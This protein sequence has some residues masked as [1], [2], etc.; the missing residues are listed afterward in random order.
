[1]DVVAQAGRKKYG[2]LL[3][4]QSQAC[5]PIA[6]SN[7]LFSSQLKNRIVMMTKNRSTKTASIKYL[8][9][10]PL[11]ALLLLAFSFNS[12][13]LQRNDRQTEKGIE[14]L[15]IDTLPSGEVFKVV[16]E[17]P[18]FPG[19]AEIPHAEKRKKCSNEKMLNFIS[20]SFL[21]KVEN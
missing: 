4:R 8:A 10:L 5:P 9:G 19:C 6:I 16:E 11:L 15:S 12:T 18:V 20:L 14:A 1:M 17:M 2:R 13:D 7:S 3:L 21:P